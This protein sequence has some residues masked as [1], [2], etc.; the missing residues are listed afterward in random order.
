[1]ADFSDLAEA[2]EDLTSA[3]DRL[4]QLDDVA[5][6]MERL[7]NAQRAAAVAE[8]DELRP[9]RRYRYARVADFLGMKKA[10]VQNLSR[11]ELPRCG[12]AYVLGVD[13]MAYR[14]E[15]TYDVAAAY[16]RHRRRRV[17]SQI[18]ASSRAAEA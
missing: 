15:I 12:G 7:A 16:K 10:S 14:G 11:T 8:G 1:M 5:D 3:A 18:P 13:I 17:V 9:D 2:L 4:D 6:E